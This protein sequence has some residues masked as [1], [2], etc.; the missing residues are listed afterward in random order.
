[1][2][3]KYHLFHITKNTIHSQD[4]S[5]FDDVFDCLSE[6]VSANVLYYEFD[7]QS[8]IFSSD[9]EV[10]IRTPLRCFHM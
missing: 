5:H 1:M 8:N 9:L 7:V 3:N 10:E 2:C 6:F 4:Y